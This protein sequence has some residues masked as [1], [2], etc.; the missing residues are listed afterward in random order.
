MINISYMKILI[1]IININDGNRK[2]VRF[3][4]EVYIYK[5][6]LNLIIFLGLIK[7]LILENRR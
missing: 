7:L 4:M 3:L 6:I 1:L 5:L 2:F